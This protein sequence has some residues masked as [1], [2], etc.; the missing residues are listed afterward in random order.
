MFRNLRPEKIT[1]TLVQ[2]QARI[3]ARFPAAG[4]ARVAAELIQLSKAAEAR[5]AAIARPNVLIRTGAGLLILTGLFALGY[6]ATIR[7]FNTTENNLFQAAQG[8][9]AMLQI[10]FFIGA[11]VFFLVSFEDRIKRRRAL[12]YLHELRSIVHVVDMHQL[13]K[14]PSALIEAG[15]STPASPVRTMTRFELIRYLDYCS[16]LLSLSSK[17]AAIY[18]GASHDPVIGAAVNEIEQLTTNLS[19]KIWQKIMILEEHPEAAKPVTE[20][21]PPA[22]PFATA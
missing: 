8:V 17:V 10:V 1:E 21:L 7:Q 4:L 12:T 13:T 15:P 3:E 2:L 9:E 6:L 5:A 11:S 16:E 20:P 19:H 22:P 14:D 18:S